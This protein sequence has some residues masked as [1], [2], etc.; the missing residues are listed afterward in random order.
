MEEFKGYV[1]KMSTNTG[2]E[3]ERYDG[4][5]LRGLI[6]KF[7]NVLVEHLHE[8]IRNLLQ[9]A[10]EFDVS[11]EILKKNYLAFEKRL[12][13]E[14]SWVSLSSSLAGI[15]WPHDALL[16]SIQRSI[17]VYK[18]SRPDTT[19]SSSAAATQR[20]RMASTATSLRMYCSSPRMCYP[21]CSRG[22]W[23]MV[24]GGSC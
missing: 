18:N 19:H 2:G 11:G 8:E 22:S 20:S 13:A 6:N 3:C 10:R 15:P 16:L 12:V 23:G 4:V 9:V 17:H 21:A 14:S 5:V 7:G 24:C 1:E